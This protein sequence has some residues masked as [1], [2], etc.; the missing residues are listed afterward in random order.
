MV[1]KIIPILTVLVGWIIAAII[2]HRELSCDFVHIFIGL[3]L[4]II[5]AIL[6]LKV[7]I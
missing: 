3:G 4:V 2:I 5:V 1:S 7:K 6:L